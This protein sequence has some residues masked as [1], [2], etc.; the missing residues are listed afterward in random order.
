MS[1]ESL[2]A[3]IYETL[4]IATDLR[5]PDQQGRPVP[6]VQGGQSIHAQLT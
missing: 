4:G 6:I 2:A 5:L 3:T 1:P